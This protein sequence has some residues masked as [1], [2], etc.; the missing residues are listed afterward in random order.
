MC[1]K[2]SKKPSKQLREQLLELCGEIHE[3]DCIDPKQYFR[4]SRNLDA[5]NKKAR[6]LCRQA[7]ETLELVLADCDDEL[8]HSLAV[9]DVQPGGD[10]ARLL[11]SIQA[12]LDADA[13]DRQFVLSRLQAQTPRL[14]AELARSISRKRVPQ[15]VFNVFLKT[16]SSREKRDETQNND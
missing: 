10:A 13:F 12:D 7:I 5:A 2:R 3:D 9:A 8:M 11:V 4:P 15:L 16:D 1:S 14:R 6:Q